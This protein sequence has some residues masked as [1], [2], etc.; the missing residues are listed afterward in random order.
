MTDKERFEK[1][2]E[3]SKEHFGNRPMMMDGV[4]FWM[5]GRNASHQFFIGKVGHAFLKYSV[6]E[7]AWD[8]EGF[9]TKLDEH[10]RAYNS[11]DELVKNAYLGH[12]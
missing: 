3:Q 6:G 5:V 8:D 4:E 11:F 7:G 9:C 1:F 10:I 2:V 12:L